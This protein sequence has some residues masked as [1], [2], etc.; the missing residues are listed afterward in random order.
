MAMGDEDRL[1]PRRVLFQPA[2]IGHDQIN[3]GRGIHIGESHP[4]I[5]D[6]QPLLP[7]WPVAID[8]AIHPDFTGPAKGKIDQAVF[9]AH[10]FSLL[11][12]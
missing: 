4:K 10:A 6:D 9:R 3:A 11:N 2:Y 8:I 1:D 12:A 7:R 5:H